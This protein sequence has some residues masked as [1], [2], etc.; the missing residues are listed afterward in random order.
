MCTTTE[1]IGINDIEHICLPYFHIN[2]HLVICA[3][4]IDGRLW[5]IFVAGTGIAIVW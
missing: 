4:Y 3:W 5:D 2:V 1:G